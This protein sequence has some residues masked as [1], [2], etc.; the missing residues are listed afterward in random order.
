MYVRL[1]P[2]PGFSGLLLALVLAPSL[3]AAPALFSASVTT[4]E[5]ACSKLFEEPLVALRQPSP[6][7]N[8]ALAKAL[9]AFSDGGRLEKVDPL[10]T[11]LATFPD[12]A[13][14]LALRVNL[15]LLQ[16]HVGRAGA[17]LKSWETAWDFGRELQDPLGTA[18]ANRA[19]GELLELNASLGRPERLEV[20]ISQCQGRRLSG[21]VTEK[22]SAARESLAFIRTTPY[23][24]FQCG[25]V[26]LSYLKALETPFG[27]IEHPELVHG[28]QGTSLAMNAALAQELDLKL[29]MAKCEPGASF[30]AP[31][32][33]HFNS[34]HFSALLYHSAGKSLLQDPAL[35]DA[36]VSDTVIDGEASG[37]ALVPAGP[38]PKGWHA[39]GEEEGNTV[40]GKGAWGPGRPDDTRPG[41]RMIAS[42][43]PPP[44][45]GLPK[46]AYHAN[47]VSLNLN[48]PVVDYQPILGPRVT[49]NVTYNQREFSQP[50]VFDYCNLGPKWTFSY[51]AC[52]K[53]DT[54]TPLG[55]VAMCCPGG[56]GLVFH[57]KGDG[58]FRA[59]GRTQALLSRLPAGGFA[60]T[61]PD[62]R[63]EF[64][65]LSDRGWGLRR[66]VLT[67]IQDKLGREVR[68]TWDPLLRMQT[69]TDAAGQA[70]KLAYDWPL[71]PLKVT[72][73]S[74]PFGT[75]TTFH[76]DPAGSLESVQDAHGRVT[77]FVYGPTQADPEMPQ[78]ALNTMIAPGSTYHFRFGE[79]KTALGLTRWIEGTKAG[80]GRTERLEAGAGYAPGND[81]L[82]RIPELLEKYY[83]KL[84]P[85]A[86]SYRETRFWSDKDQAGTPTEQIRWGHG[87]GGF[88]SGIVV[89]DQVGS[90]QLH[91]LVNAGDFWGGT[92]PAA[93]DAKYPLTPEGAIQPGKI[94]AG[95]L[96]T[97]AFAHQLAPVYDGDRDLVSCDYWSQTGNLWRTARS[98]DLAGH[99]LDEQLPN[100]AKRIWTWD[101]AVGDMLTAQSPLDSKPTTF[102]YD[103]QHRLKTWTPANGRT[104]TAN[105]DDRGR[106]LSWVP[107]KGLAWKL[108][109]DAKGLLDR[110]VRGGRTWTLGFNHRH[111][112]VNLTLPGGQPWT[113][114]Y[115]AW[116]RPVQAI[117]RKEREWRY[118][119]DGTCELKVGQAWHAIAQGKEDFLGLGPTAVPE[120]QGDPFQSVLEGASGPVLQALFF[121]LSAR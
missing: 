43:L 10:E 76:Y 14:S 96:G 109:R 98:F 103:D 111:Q 68:L 1:H 62:G 105:Y 30:P 51:L 56:G 99:L 54:T 2:L 113:F 7:E 55:D 21:L 12:S 81:A 63:R 91:V 106:L 75:T 70:T 117:G 3:P 118:R 24:A 11:F 82:P 114:S 61:Y 110:I 32:I 121:P 39:V 79:A 8:Q 71:D 108:H 80:L 37:Y 6:A 49:F 83:R 28:G 42:S 74:D 84:H 72:G 23:H 17:A 97:P 119:D 94:F 19:L 44:G 57:A 107:A 31:S 13:W 9:Q 100:G 40:W 46:L 116:D 77:R 45:A 26:A 34:G 73:V 16:R 53:D 65:E 35:G 104:W 101:M 102:T 18:L 92:F 86:L 115:D 52:L 67:R 36:W 95:M 120:T 64:Y 4:S 93:R 59:E 22:L 90:G 50:Q 78:D 29:Q 20:L 60:L 41:S 5:I 89:G 58:T 85:T 38:L 87:P 15:G 112:V 27:F 47:L 69:I 33:V 25:P 66:T 48:I 88:S